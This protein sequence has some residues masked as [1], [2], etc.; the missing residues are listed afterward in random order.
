MITSFSRRVLTRDNGLTCKRQLFRQAA[1]HAWIFIRRHATRT[2]KR[3]PSAVGAA[4]EFHC[5]GE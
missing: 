5:R 2:C 1:M 4:G 3:A